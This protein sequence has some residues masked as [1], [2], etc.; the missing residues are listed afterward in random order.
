MSIHTKRLRHRELLS[1]LYS[2]FAPHSN[3]ATGISGMT[4]K[5]KITVTIALMLGMALAALDKT[6]VGTALPSIV[7]KLGGI[8]L[9]S[10]VLSA[11]L[12]TAELAQRIPQMVN[13]LR[14]ILNGQ[15]FFAPGKEQIP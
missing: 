7:G 1:D 5:A 8:N 2:F 10:W 3:T 12:I 6:I 4:G 9:Y 11:Y 15:P 13:A 14:A